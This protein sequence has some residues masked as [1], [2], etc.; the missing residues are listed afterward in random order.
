MEQEIARQHQYEE[1]TEQ[2]LAAAALEDLNMPDP[3]KYNMALF[4]RL[5]RKVLGE[6]DQG[7]RTSFDTLL[8]DMVAANDENASPEDAK[9]AFGRAVAF[10]NS[11]TLRECQ[12]VTRAFTTYFH[13]ANI[14][15]ENYRVNSL[16]T[17]EREV[18]IDSADDPINAITVAYRRLVNECGE[19]TAGEKLN[20][21]EFRPVFTAHPTEARRKAMTGKIRRISLLLDERAHLGGP[22]LL[23][24]ERRMLLEIDALFRT[25]PIAIKKP[26]PV[27]EADTIIDIFDNTLFEMIPKVYRR[28]D[29]W[30]LGEK[31]G[32]MPPVCPAF[33]HPG[34]WI[35]SDRDGNPNVTAKVSRHVAEKF[36]AHMLRTLADSTR[37]VGRNLTEE[38][39]TTVP[40]ADLLNLWS[41]QIEMSEILTARAEALSQSEPHRAVMLVIANRLEATITRTADLMYDSCDEYLADLR[42][43]QDSLASCGAVRVAYGPLQTLI[44]QAETFGFNM[45]EMEFRQHSLVHT[46]ALADIREHGRWGERGELAPMTR[47]VLDTFRAI[48]NIQRRNGV[49]AA[50]RYIIS[51]TKSAQNIADVYELARLA[52]AHQE[53]VPTLDVIPLFEQVEDLKGAVETLDKMIQLPDV[54]RRLDE[55]GRK[56]EVMLGYSDSSKDAGPTSATLVLHDTQRRIAEWAERNAIDLILMH[57][58]GGAVGRGGGPAHHAVLAQPKGSVN[59]R[60][61]L[62]EQGEV[63]FARYGDPTLARRHVEEVAAATLLNSAPS[64]EWLNT[65][66]TQRYAEMADKL[67]RE[68]R[69]RYCDLLNTDGFAEWFSGVTPLT[70]I[71]LL[72]IGSRPAKRGLGAKSLDDLRTIPWI[73][74]WSQARI[75]LAAWYGLGSACEAFGDVELLRKAYAEWPLFTTFIDNIEMSIAKTDDEI[76]NMYLSLD[77]RQDLSKKVMDEMHLTRKWVLAIIGEKWPLEHRRVLGPVV[78]ARLPFVNVLSLMQVIALKRLRLESDT[79]TQDER[80]RL[81]F[82]IL[83]T[84]S[85]VAAGLQNTG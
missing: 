8:A 29:D 76:A 51:F 55:T 9:A 60:F 49:N 67:E 65:E 12:L 3:L 6:Y 42:V 84:V 34:S 37:T 4:L 66:T 23:E 70:E 82:L 17:R 7:L 71:G 45:V 43:V 33:F 52:F 50:R 21:L 36:R 77:E 61:K 48:G 35:G 28:F 24:N 44:W 13:L 18:S 22:E 72:P 57:G 31:A 16:R 62:T 79:L 40:S 54:R 63:I 85:G 69:E 1:G 47:E 19:E 30:E 83:C 25:S 53:D 74:S 10:I 38:S 32:T 81:I 14:A 2:A 56:L 64:I 11:M 68:S 41:H 27:E 26:T 46:R 39:T 58:R 80:E 73:F 75:N 15:E 5:V 20:N 59:C 78:H